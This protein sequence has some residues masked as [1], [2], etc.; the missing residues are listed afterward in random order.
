[1]T[2]L[3]AYLDSIESGG[4]ELP[5]FWV[6]SRSG[7]PIAAAPEPPGGVGY[8]L[9]WSAFH[10]HP[11]LHADASPAAYFVSDWTLQPDAKLRTLLERASGQELWSL[12][13][14]PAGSTS[15]LHVD[16]WGTH[17][18]LSQVRG[19]KK[20]R[21]YSPRDDQRMFGGE[22]DPERPDAARFPEFEQAVEY[23]CELGPGE[24]LFLPSGWWHHV[25]AIE[26][27]IT[28]SHNFLN[29]SNSELV[30]R[31]LQQHVPTMADE[32]KQALEEA[33]SA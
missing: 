17:G 33:S 25:R 11:E 19:R 27:S 5:G 32:W 16:F 29:G 7:K 20:V 30:T 1:V 21:M 10:K 9:G 28:V 4:G 2:R 26:D 14:G 8:L 15:Q 12:Y 3:S 24:M 13:V 31:C 22:V 6:D 23:D 18:I